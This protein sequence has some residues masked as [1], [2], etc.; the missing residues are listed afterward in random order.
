MATIEV[1]PN[2]DTLQPYCTQMLGDLGYG[3]CLV[4]LF[5]FVRYKNVANTTKS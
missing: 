4:E 1:K 2:A 3:Q 5:G